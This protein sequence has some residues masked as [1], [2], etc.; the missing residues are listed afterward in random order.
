MSVKTEAPEKELSPLEKKLL[1][2]RLDTRALAAIGK[3]ERMARYT[4]E[5]RAKLSE[6]LD[7]IIKT[8]GED[9]EV[10]YGY[11]AIFLKLE[12]RS[13]NMEASVILADMLKGEGLTSAEAK[14]GGVDITMPN[15]K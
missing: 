5:L 3:P 12:F 7:D 2:L 13:D 15:L 11:P 6:I 1:Q 10:W 14:Y 8:A 9:R 4:V